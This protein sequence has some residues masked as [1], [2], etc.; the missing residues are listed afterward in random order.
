M[1]YRIVGAGPSGLAAALT[2]RRAGA[3]VEVYE[4]RRDCGMRFGGDLQGLENWSDDLDVCDELREYGIDVDFH[5]A[6]VTRGV[7]TNGRRED[8]LSFQRPALYLLKRGTAPDAL[9][10]SLKRQA[11]AAG[12]RLHFEQT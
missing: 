10:Q 8:V 11:L 9:D 12:V 3:E 2:L 5:C 1:T 7:Q 4:P 6:P